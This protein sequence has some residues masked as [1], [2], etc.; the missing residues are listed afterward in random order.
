[1]VN[2]GKGAEQDQPQGELP[3]TLR[4][5][6]QEGRQGHAKKEH[7]HHLSPAPQISQAT[8]G[9]RAQTKHQKRPSTIRHQ[10][11]PFCKAKIQRYRRNGGCKD[12]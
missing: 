7:Q 8:T 2:G 12:Q 11:L 4:E 1:M 3:N 6:A 9:Y 5:R 10:I